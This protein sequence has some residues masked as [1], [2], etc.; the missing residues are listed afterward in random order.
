MIGGAFTSQGLSSYATIQKPAERQSQSIQT[1]PGSD[2]GNVPALSNPI[3]LTGVRFVKVTGF[4]KMTA[5][6]IKQNEAVLL[7]RLENRGCYH[8]GPVERLEVKQPC[9]ATAKPFAIA[10]FKSATG[11]PR[12]QILT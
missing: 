5:A 10:T 9:R 4:E 2:T 6:D 3:T 1:D 12:S 7:E 8:G 11:E